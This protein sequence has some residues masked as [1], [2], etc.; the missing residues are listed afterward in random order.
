MLE[1]QKISTRKLTSLKIV[2][3]TKQKIKNLNSQKPDAYA[4]GF[5]FTFFQSFKIYKKYIHPH[6]ILINQEYK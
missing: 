5:L 4:L 2:L 6:K 3:K 1:T